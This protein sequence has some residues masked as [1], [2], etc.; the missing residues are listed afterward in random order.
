MSGSGRPVALVTGASRGI[1]LAIAR[2]LARTHT[3]VAGARSTAALA[4]LVDEVPDVVPFVCD[5]GDGDSVATAVAALDADRLDV[6]VHSAGIADERPFDTFTRDDWRRSFEVNVFGVA[7]LTARLLPALRRARGTVVFLNSGSGTFSY[8][9][10]A[11]YSG[12]K[13]ALRTMAD[14]LREEERT[15]GVRVVSVHPGF[16]DTDMARTIRREAGREGPD[17]SYVQ[18]ETIAAGVRVAVDAPHEAQFETIAIRPTLR[19]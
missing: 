1:G 10:G 6:V 14:C 7:D 4:G 12:T 9:D 11:V 15:N 2:D 5:V 16:V 13:F 17:E 3:V 19:A 8:P 18:P